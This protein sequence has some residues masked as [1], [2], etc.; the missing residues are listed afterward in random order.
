M[1]QRKSFENCN[2]HCVSTGTSQKPA[3]LKWQFIKKCASQKKKWG[4]KIKNSCFSSK[5]DQKTC[6]S[7]N[8]GPN[9]KTCIVKVRAA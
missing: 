5:I 1:F 7:K 4:K 9:S 2:D 8:F 3:H 6:I